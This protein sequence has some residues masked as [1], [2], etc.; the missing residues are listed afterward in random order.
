MKGY[1]VLDE[2]SISELLTMRNDQN[3]SNSEIAKSLDISRSTVYRLIGA[4]GPRRAVIRRTSTPSLMH[5]EKEE[6]PACLKVDAAPINLTGAYGKYT[7]DQDRKTVAVLAETEDWILGGS[8]PVDQL[9][10]FI[11][12]LQ[13]IERNIG[14]AQPKLE[15]W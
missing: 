13:A 10:T 1:R 2:I 11:K 7:I 9:S 12:E 4:G 14:N 3:M 5:P 6:I 15:V 8:I